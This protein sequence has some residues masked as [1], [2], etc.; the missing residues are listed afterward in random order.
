MFN[1]CVDLQKLNEVASSDA[2]SMADLYYAVL[3]L[4][5][6]TQRPVD[7]T[8]ALKN[9]QVALKKDDSASR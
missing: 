5:A 4:K 7:V 6:L 1:C 9:I 2:S 3:G 8:K